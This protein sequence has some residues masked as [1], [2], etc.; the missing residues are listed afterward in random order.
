MST[1]E[2]K[3]V[4]IWTDGC[5]DM[6]HFGHANAC[7]QSKALGDYLIVGVHSDE[8]ITKHKG[9]PVFNEK[10][11]Y[12]MVKS[13]KWVDEIVENAPYVTT[14]ETL[15][16]YDCDY[17]AH[18]DD[19]TLTAEGVDTYHI[20]K[21][22]NRYKEVKRTQ[23]VSTTDLVG[24]MLL[25]TKSHHVSDERLPSAEQCDEMGSSS[26][27]DTVS[28][29]TKSCQFL[30]TTKKIIQFSNGRDPKPNDR[31]VYTAGA[32]DLFH[33]G[34]IDFLEKA[35]KEG[36]YLIVGLHSDPIVNRYKGNNYPIMN[37]HERTLSVLACKYVDEVVIG[38]PYCVTKEIM[39]SLKI[40]VVIHGETE[41]APEVDGSDPYMEA[42][43]R[44]KFKTIDS[45]NSLTTA[46]I[47]ERII[48]H[49]L[50]YEKR[51]KKKQAKEAAVYKIAMEKKKANPDEFHVVNS[52]S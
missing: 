43:A 51:N 2:K 49:R 38:A 36:D 4:R 16:K 34:F 40:D 28:P 6:V 37:V 26:S 25:L 7:R 21:Q 5:F 13:I 39:D 46:D 18:G 29:W 22:N 45:G 19:I 8:E 42:K 50:E 15:N 24:R 12:K 9:P 47:V 3:S 17:C 35:K 27:G 31:I 30:A 44:G 11:R 33:V 32:F 41:V 48:N 20:V 23:G 52:S 1:E 14:L 10:E